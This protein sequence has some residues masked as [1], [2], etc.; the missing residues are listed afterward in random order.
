M[1]STSLSGISPAFHSFFFLSHILSYINTKASVELIPKA[2]TRLNAGLILFRQIHSP[3]LFY[4]FSKNFLR[5]MLLSEC[6][7]KVMNS[8]KKFPCMEYGI[9]CLVKVTKGCFTA[10]FYLLQSLVYRLLGYASMK[11]SS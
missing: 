9:L 11:S 3:I 7:S 1:Y 2:E 10:Q 5:E 8:L 4:T 6:P